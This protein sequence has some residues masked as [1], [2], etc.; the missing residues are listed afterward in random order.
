[1]AILRPLIR[2]YLFG[3]RNPHSI[4]ISLH[5]RASRLRVTLGVRGSRVHLKQDLSFLQRAVPAAQGAR[6]HRGWHDPTAFMGSI[7][8][9][10]WRLSSRSSL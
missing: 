4:R 9:I 1:M 10:G 8:R 7:P 2:K 3:Y 6:W 5:A